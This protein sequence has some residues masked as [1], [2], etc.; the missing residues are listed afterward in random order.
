MFKCDNCGGNLIFDPGTKSL[1]CQSCNTHFRITP[2]RDKELETSEDGAFEA[3]VFTCPN[4][5]GELIGFTE[6]IVSFCPFCGSEVAMKTEKVNKKLPELIIPFE[7]SRDECKSIYQS[8][9]RRFIFAPK[10]MNS[11][12]YIDRVQGV[13]VPYWYYVCN[14]SGSVDAN[15]IDTTRNGDFI[16]KDYYYVKKNVS[17][18]ISIPR[19]ASKGL[20]DDLSVG[21]G[22]FEETKV[23]PFS[24]QYLSGFYADLPDVPAEYYVDESENVA[25][26]AAL[27]RILYEADGR[28]IQSFDDND[29]KIDVEAKSLA[30]PLYLMTWR[31]EKKVSYSLINGQNGTL[32]SRL[33]VDVFKYFLVSV[34]IA[35]PLFLLFYF[36]RM[37]ILPDSLSVYVGVGLIISMILG[38]HAG[39][40]AYQKERLIFGYPMKKRLFGKNKAIK[41]AGHKV[42]KNIQYK[43]EKNIDRFKNPLM[44]IWLVFFAIIVVQNINSSGLF[45]VLTRFFASEKT[46]SFF[47]IMILIVGLYYAARMIISAIGAMKCASEHKK[48][49]FQR[50]S[51]LFFCDGILGSIGIILSGYFSQFFHT[52]NSY[53]YWISLYTIAAA[54]LILFLMIVEYNIS[55]TRPVQYFEGRKGLNDH[56]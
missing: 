48:G 8:G 17:G 12:E 33:P 26:D 4:C 14:F 18:H 47:R 9:V 35:L 45:K 16:D 34:L 21:A 50:I 38:F 53:Y 56:A 7:V 32:S 19:D 42:K 55:V 30:S 23:R 54:F 49:W 46:M 44:I 29:L 11:D 28:E 41:N 6:S 27:D 25:K 31:D 43:N 2:E 10:K 5:G 52:E 36:G 3:D 37:T 22:S 39:D 13:Y 24:P 1:V 20:D 40:K 15:F 51:V